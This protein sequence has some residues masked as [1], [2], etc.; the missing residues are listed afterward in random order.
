MK[1][2]VQL[3]EAKGERV[4]ALDAIQKA[5]T[6]E[7]RELTT[8][9]SQRAEDIIAEVEDLDKQ[10]ERAE[11]IEATLKANV[12]A[13]RH[14]AAAAG[15]AGHDTCVSARCS[16]PRPRAGAGCHRARTKARKSAARQT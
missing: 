4:E 6:V 16:P 3:R 9:E 15:G 10:I 5:A 12:V 7:G 13:P 2:P 11:K 14:P 1:T 8:E